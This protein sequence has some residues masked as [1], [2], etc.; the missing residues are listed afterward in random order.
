MGHENL[1][2]FFNENPEISREIAKRMVYDSSPWVKILDEVNILIQEEKYLDA[3]NKCKEGIKLYPIVEIK[4]LRKISSIYEDISEWDNAI[5]YIN[6]CKQ[7]LSPVIE[8]YIQQLSSLNYTL[9]YLFEKKGLISE[10]LV[11]VNAS[12]LPSIENMVSY[13]YKA[14]LL[15][16]MNQ[17]DEAKLLIE[18]CILSIKPQDYKDYIHL[19]EL[20][21]LRFKIDDING[22]QSYVERDKELF[23]YYCL[24]SL[25]FQDG[26]I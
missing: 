13:K 18:A 11:S 10:A 23:D 14:D 4:F 19:V 20:F 6:R 3:I 12:I 8:N 26:D 16:Q 17:C 1:N 9:A 2:S 25:P 5:T 7:I 21:E 22:D 15:I 24:K